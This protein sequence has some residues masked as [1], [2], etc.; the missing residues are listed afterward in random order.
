MHIFFFCVFY[1]YKSKNKSVFFLFTSTVFFCSSSFSVYF[2]YLSFMVCCPKAQYL[3]TY[4]CV[5]TNQSEDFVWFCQDL[6][7]F[8]DFFFS[9][10]QTERNKTAFYLLLRFSIVC[11]SIESSDKLSM[12]NK[13]IEW[14]E[15]NAIFPIKVTKSVNNLYLYLTNNWIKYFTFIRS[16]AF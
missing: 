5:Y 3:C 15:A 14:L 10:R 9:F 11:V 6:A 1:L 16:Y 8:V 13:E 2:R 12:V 7:E 4:L